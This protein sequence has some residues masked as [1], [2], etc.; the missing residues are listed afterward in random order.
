LPDHSGIQNYNLL[1]CTL[2][3]VVE[4]ESKAILMFWLLKNFPNYRWTSGENLFKSI[5]PKHGFCEFLVQQNQRPDILL[6]KGD[7]V[8]DICV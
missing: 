6:W 8:E 1:D 5:S 3:V 4:D 2:P 7:V